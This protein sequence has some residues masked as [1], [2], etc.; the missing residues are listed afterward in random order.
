MVMSPFGDLLLPQCEI[1]L[2]V[3]K[4]ERINGFCQEGL[5]WS[6]QHT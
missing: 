5:W 6:L 2:V 4:L 3:F 1:E